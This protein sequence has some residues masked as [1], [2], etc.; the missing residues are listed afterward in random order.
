MQGTACQ[1]PFYLHG[2]RRV[3]SQALEFLGWYS[4]RFGVKLAVTQRQWSPEK[5][6]LVRVRSRSLSL[7]HNFI[8]AN[9]GNVA[10][11]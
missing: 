2:A 10:H 7:P 11:S 6:E 4:V 5:E 8:S 3:L 9:P 1:N